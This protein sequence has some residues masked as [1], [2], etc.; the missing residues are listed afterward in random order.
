MLSRSQAHKTGAA[1]ANRP[2]ILKLEFSR[3]ATCTSRTEV[4]AVVAIFQDAQ[5]ANSITVPVCLAAR[6]ISAR[7]APLPLQ[8]LW[9]LDWI[10]FGPIP[11]ACSWAVLTSNRSGK[12]TQTSGALLISHARRHACERQSTPLH[13]SCVQLQPVRSP[14]DPLRRAAQ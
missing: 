14:A 9:C 5:E 3:Y 13:V 7:S 10:Y 12:T 6:L 1:P 8:S 4:P 2:R 11:R